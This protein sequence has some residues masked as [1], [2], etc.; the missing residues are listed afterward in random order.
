M[1]MRDDIT[2][3]VY[4]LERYLS[5]PVRSPVSTKTALPTPLTGVTLQ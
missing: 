5:V 3:W 4:I 1:R 2:L